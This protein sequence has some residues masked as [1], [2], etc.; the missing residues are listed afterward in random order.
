V[1]DVVTGDDL[2]YPATVE[3]FF[4]TRAGHPERAQHLHIPLNPAC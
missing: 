3:S 4:S 1:L 2:Y